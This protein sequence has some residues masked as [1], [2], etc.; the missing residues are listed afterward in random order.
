MLPS[1][2]LYASG[3]QAL[4]PCCPVT[5]PRPQGSGQHT[6]P[7]QCNALCQLHT[8][9]LHKKWEAAISSKTCLE[10]GHEGGRQRIVVA[11]NAQLPVLVAPKAVH[12]ARLRERNRVR[13]PAADHSDLHQSSS[14]VH[15]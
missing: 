5:A 3:L 1:L 12:G 14:E 2:V 9:L 11:A 15:C 13:V 7:V 6:L 8:V 4:W 10:A